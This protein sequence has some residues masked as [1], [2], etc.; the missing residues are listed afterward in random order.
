MRLLWIYGLF[1]YREW[2]FYHVEA[3]HRIIWYVFP[4]FHLTEYLSEIS[5]YHH[6]GY[7]YFIVYLFLWIFKKM[8]LSDWGLLFPSYFLIGIVTFTVSHLP[9]NLLTTSPFLLES[10]FYLGDSHVPTSRRWIMT[11]PSHPWQSRWFFLLLP[12]HLPW[13]PCHQGWPYYVVMTLFVIKKILIN[14]TPWYK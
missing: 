5:K 7:V 1:L 2:T 9:P 8:S 6:I 3:F 11:G 12:A 14:F 13:L 4:F 10:Y